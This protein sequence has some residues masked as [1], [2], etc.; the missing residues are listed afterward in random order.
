M[1][2][3]LAKIFPCAEHRFCVR[4][5]HE[6][7]KIY[8]RG[9]QLKEKLWICAQA[10]TLTHFERAMK[11]LADYHQEAHDWLRKIPPSHWARSHFTGV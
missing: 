5:I 7:M 9:D 3:A 6:N 2:P 4:H 11:E 1:I 8:W 10:S